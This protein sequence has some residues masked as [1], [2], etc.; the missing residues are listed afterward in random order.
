MRNFKNILEKG[1]LVLLCLVIFC[2]KKEENNMTTTPENEIKTFTLTND[3]NCSVTITNFGAT[4]MA[5]KMPDKS[6]TMGNVTLAYDTPEEY[7]N[8]NIFLGANRIAKGKFSLDGQEYSLPT[9]NGNNHLHGGPQGF[10]KKV[11]EVVDYSNEPDNHFVELRYVSQDGEQG[12]PGK[13]TVTVKYSLTD[14]NELVIDYYAVTDKKTIVNLTHH[15]YFNLKDGGK[16]TILNH[17]LKI[18]ADNYTPVNSELIPTGKIEPVKGTPMDFTESTA[19][20][21]RIN[22]D[23]PQLKL[24]GGYDH[25]WVLNKKE[26]SLA[27][28]AT[29]YEPETGRMMEVF[30]TLPGLQFYS[31]NFLNGTDVG[32]QGV[33][34]EYRNALCLEPQFFPD[35]PNQPN[36]PSP[37]LSPGEEYKHKIIYKF[38]VLK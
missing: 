29:V 30:T 27:L 34:F 2:E 4:V 37:V 12:Y 8:G 22:D 1:I 11:W 23:F 26:N 24:A 13:L 31:G 25:N 14:K 16:T 19:I 28:A 3:N 35:S 21:K 17:K 10:Y 5:V 7:R 18:N 9:N 32:N 6:G 20:G 33:K 15:S 36:F 38:S